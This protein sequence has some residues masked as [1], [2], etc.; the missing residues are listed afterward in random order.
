MKYR[1]MDSEGNMDDFDKESDAQVVYEE[2]KKEVNE[3]WGFA[4]CHIH[5]CYH[6]ETPYK[7]CELIESYDN[8]TVIIDDG[9]IPPD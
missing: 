8:T 2:K 9:G 1:V 3:S 7:P 5:K 4:S 6:D